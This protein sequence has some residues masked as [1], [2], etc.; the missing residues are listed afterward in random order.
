MQ[1]MLAVAL[2]VLALAGPVE[3][4]EPR[5]IPFEGA[6]VFCH[7]L[8]HQ[9]L[10]PIQSTDDLGDDPS[11]TLLI[12]IGTPPRKQDFRAA[13]GLGRFC[14]K[15][16]NLLVASDRAFIEYDTRIT[17]DGR[18]LVQP[19]GSTY[20][21][22]PECPWIP[23]TAG[24]DHPLFT[25]LRKGIATNR[26]SYLIIL[27]MG[28]PPPPFSIAPLLRFSDDTRRDDVPGGAGGMGM[29][30][31]GWVYMLGSPKDAPPRG[32]IL[33]I[34]GHGMFMNGMM[35]QGDNDNFDFGENAIRWLREGPDGKLRSKA[36]LILNGNVVK[37]FNMNLSP[38]AATPKPQVPVPPGEA[39][40]RL[41]RGMEE[42]GMFHKMLRGLLR[43][44]LHRTIGVILAFVTFGLLLYGA[45]KFMDGRY[46]REATVPLMAGT[47]ATPVSALSRGQ[48]RNLALHRQADASSPA[49]QMVAAWLRAEFGVVASAGAAVTLQASGFFLFRWRLQRRAD[50]VFALARAPGTTT[51]T[52]H[53]FASL[54]AILP[55][56][57]AAVAS[58]R[59]TLLVDGKIVRHAGS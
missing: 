36:L 44:N 26:P 46:A 43:D 1:R 56:L 27:K 37:D 47:V 14:S 34:G 19:V 58:G 6:E 31:G 28:P 2:A 52:R 17:I 21:S 23:S 49:V 10:Q 35:L 50:W 5:T 32:R 48:Q 59:L 39:I 22:A 7:I 12:A 53:Q 57:S 33:F 18:R 16:G 45:K 25:S 54:V 42:E 29:G 3:S 24:G 20:R 13:G 38:P 41:L 51:V 55:E 40:N 11:D 4:Q 30:K 9:G 8:F 15:G